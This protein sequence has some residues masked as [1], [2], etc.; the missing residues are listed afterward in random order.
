M[1]NI[2]DLISTLPDPES[3]RRFLVQLTEKH[4]SY[5]KKLAKN[6]ALLSDVL[7]LVG[8]SPLLAATMMQHPEYIGWLQ[9][10]RGENVLRNKEELLESL[11]RFSLT[12]SQ[13]EPHVLLSRF[14]RREL[15]R[16]YL[17]DIRRLATVAEIT[18]EISNLADAILEHSLRLSRQQLDNRYGSP[19]EQD[20]KGRQR[21]AKISI[22]SLGKLG[23][24]ELNYSSDIDLLFIY[25][26]EGTTA[27][28]GTRDPITNREYFVK[29][30]E[31]ITKLVGEQSGEGAAYRVDLRLRPHGRVGPLAMSLK[32]TVR[33]Y[34]NE[35]AAWERQV[36]IRSRSSAGSE[37]LFKRFWEE[38]E[39]NV[40]S[41]EG[42]VENALRD[43]R[44]SKQK[45]DLENINSKGTNVK[46]G[47]GGIREIEFIAQALQLAHGGRDKWL[48]VPH[49]L[50]SLSRLADRRLLD[51]AELTKLADGYS[52]LRQLEHIIQ[53]ENGLQTHSVPNEPA[54]RAV[55]GRRMRF[56]DAEEFTR[57]METC[58]SNVNAVFRR[59]F[60]DSSIENAKPNEP[61]T[62]RPDLAANTS[63]VRENLLA[64]SGPNIFAGEVLRVSPRF[65]ELL[66]ADST[67]LKVIPKHNADFPDRN[68]LAE[69]ANTVAKTD[70]FRS[71]LAVL[72]R[73]WHRMFAEI[74]AFD[75][76]DKIYLKRAKQLQTNLAEA[77]I[78]TAMRIT[79][80]ELA[81]RFGSDV[82]LRLAIMGLGK[83][84]GAGV[85][86]D[87]DLDLVA[88]YEETSPPAT[89]TEKTAEIAS[90]AVEIFVNTLSAM[91]R[92]GSLY[93]VDLRLR[94]HGKNGPLAISRKG[95]AEYMR[96]SSAIWELLALVKLRGVGGDIVVAKGIESEV[97]EIIHE[98]AKRIDPAELAT[99]TRRIRFSLEK[100][101]ADIRRSRDIDIKYGEGGML[102]IY[103]AIRFLQLRDGLADD[104][105]TRSTDKTLERLHAA[106]SL[107]TEL[108]E[109]LLAGYR[110]IST[111]DHDLR[112][113]VGRTTRLPLANRHALVI[114][115]ERMKLASI[116]DLL[117]QLTAH[118]LDIRNAFDEILS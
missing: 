45:I 118:R 8:Y 111:L 17:R 49:T 25:S 38:V 114:I 29:L 100:E 99:E 110:F 63:A 71:R 70:D 109:R 14:R 18:E 112:L 67:I 97:R 91:T 65:G 96:E 86:Y 22:V 82:D 2:D 12:N 61:R 83:L 68:Y 55:V 23:S 93:R 36:L 64:M 79:H 27:G 80:D 56:S 116:D 35:A 13:V 59:V 98:R 6:D 117:E 42:S 81:V 76:L 46:L 73:T 89:G 87:S 90:K 30:G 60:S 101:R 115:A 113:T 94:P 78:E 66:S 33:Y 52:F 19:Q 28:V 11:A 62:T 106:G 9:R 92:D 1:N 40:F 43:V 103:F 31:T 47:L 84:G 24:R 77:S 41:T 3:A 39:D 107:T 50:I 105:D 74:I 48:R 88:V 16:I 15:L 10:K 53:M 104:E 51:E 75:A 20:D 54:A 21:P 85:D 102:D 72:R 69:L 108:F 34:V 7:T 4:P 26:D 44:E 57:E 32:D 95:F 58:M 5:E 37:P